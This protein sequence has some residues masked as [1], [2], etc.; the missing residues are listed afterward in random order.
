MT[1]GGAPERDRTEMVTSLL[2]RW[3]GGDREAGDQL[4]EQLYPELRRLAASYMRS[5]RPDHT[6]QPTALVHELYLKLIAGASLEWED[7]AHFF[8]FAARKLRHILV[9]HARRDRAGREVEKVMISLERD[10]GW[11]GIDEADIVALGQAME[12]LEAIDA[13]SCQALE[14]RLFA[15]L[16]EAESAEVMAVSVPTVRRDVRFARAF[17]ASQLNP[18]AKNSSE[19]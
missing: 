16:T 10:S 6:L 8:A 5:E 13:R 15:G 17:L 9:D 7:R 12:R 11:S 4:M 2:R 14:L 19:A 18:A 1:E 3:R